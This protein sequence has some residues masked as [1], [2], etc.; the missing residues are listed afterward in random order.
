MSPRARFV[1]E[2]FTERVSPHAHLL[3]SD[4]ARGVIPRSRRAIAALGRDARVA[5][6]SDAYRNPRR[7]VRSRRA[8]AGLRPRGSRSASRVYVRR[9]ARVRARPFSSAPAPAAACASS[10]RARQPRPSRDSATPTR[11]SSTTSSPALPPRSS[12]ASESV[13]DS[14]DA[15]ACDLRRVVG[16]L[17]PAMTHPRPRWRSRASWSSAVSV[18]VRRRLRRRGGAGRPRRH[19]GTLLQRARG[20]DVRQVQP[21]VVRT[22]RFPP[23]DDRPRLRSRRTYADQS[24]PRSRGDRRCG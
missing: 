6:R 4:G 22:S 16:A 12:A 18:R 17:S 2:P 14:R 15:A 24:D 5:S 20:R 13:E 3:E 1:S 10:P 9:P 23:R 21:S 19:R 8:V 11:T 7:G